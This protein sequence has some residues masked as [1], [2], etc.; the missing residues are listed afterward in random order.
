[1]HRIYGFVDNVQHCVYMCGNSWQ[2]SDMAAAGTAG[3][4]DWRADVLLAV[5]DV[6]TKDLQCVHADLRTYTLVHSG[7]GSHVL[8]ALERTISA[9]VNDCF[10]TSS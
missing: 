2:P 1:M 8:D 7:D 4:L 10:Y 5:H 3:T 6:F 9:Q